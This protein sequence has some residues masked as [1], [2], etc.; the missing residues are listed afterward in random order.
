MDYNSY[1]CGINSD[2]AFYDVVTIEIIDLYFF[3]V[4]CTRTIVV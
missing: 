1:Q 3:E 2:Y 4:V